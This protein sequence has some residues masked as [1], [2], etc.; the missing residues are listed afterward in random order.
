MGV[1]KVLDVISNFV[2]TPQFLGTCVVIL[3]IVVVVIIIDV[4]F[5]VFVVAGA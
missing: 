2:L 1:I 5:V 4:V 3:V